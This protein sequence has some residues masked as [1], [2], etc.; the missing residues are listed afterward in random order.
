MDGPVGVKASTTH[1]PPSRRPSRR[2][3][4]V[5]PVKSRIVEATLKQVQ[6]KTIGQWVSHP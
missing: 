5:D 6:D 2:A 3:S 1:D 4:A